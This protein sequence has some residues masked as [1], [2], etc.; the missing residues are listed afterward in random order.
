MNM[1]LADFIT[2][3][4]ISQLKYRYVRGLDTQDWALVK[5]CFTENASVWY[6][7]GKF[8]RTGRDDI[9]EFLKGL[10]TPSFY[11][12]HIVLHPEIDLTSATTAKG[13][14]RLQDIV[15]FTEENPAFA[16][17][18]IKGGEEMTGA[19]YYHDEY[20]KGADGWKISRMGYVR[21]FEAI[22]R[23]KGRAGFEVE[24]NTARGLVTA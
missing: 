4:E 14:W 2:L 11:S 16:H 10:V 12:S 8:S 7:G 13:I 20:Q 22:E 5:D 24:T 18:N 1:N 19:A 9:M 23:P 3:H 6:S 21:I 17:A 15:H